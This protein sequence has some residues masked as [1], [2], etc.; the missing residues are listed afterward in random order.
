MK[1]TAVNEIGEGYQGKSF[2][3]TLPEYE[4][5]KCSLYVWG[6]NSDSQ[7]GLLNDE[8]LD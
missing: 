7:L 8:S 4:N 3:V 2:F 6:D 1:V 5:T